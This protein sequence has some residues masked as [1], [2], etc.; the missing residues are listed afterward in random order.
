MYEFPVHKSYLSNSVYEDEDISKAVFTM[1]HDSPLNTSH[2]NVGNCLTN[3]K[4][5]LVKTCATIP[6]GLK[7]EDT[8]R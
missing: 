8:R 2:M 1:E 3:C 6:M 7:W 5:D 4:R